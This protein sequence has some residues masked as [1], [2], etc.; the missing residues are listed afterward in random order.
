MARPG[1]L[2]I[3]A[4]WNEIAPLLP[5]APNRRYGGRPWIENGRVLERIL[6]I[7]RRDG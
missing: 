1:P 3:E 4:Q 7:L 5:E 6:S 2:L